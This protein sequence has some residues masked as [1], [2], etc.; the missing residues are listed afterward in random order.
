MSLSMASEG[1]SQFLVDFLV[2][3]LLDF[4]GLSFSLLLQFRATVLKQSVQAERSLV[5]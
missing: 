1:P 5:L 3:F 2:D 4:F